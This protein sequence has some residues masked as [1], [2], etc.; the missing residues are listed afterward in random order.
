MS[1]LLIGFQDV[2]NPATLIWVAVGVTLGYVLGAL[3]GLGKATGVAVCIP[4]TF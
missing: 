1:D 4:L 2:L 3:P